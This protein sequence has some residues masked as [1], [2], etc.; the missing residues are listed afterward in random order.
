M[1]MRWT[2]HAAR[3][4]EVRSAY[5]VFVGKPEGKS[6]FG[7]PTRFWKD[8]IKMVKAKCIKVNFLPS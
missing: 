4:R 6:P 2:G 1:S 3:M 5:K 7:R 8:N